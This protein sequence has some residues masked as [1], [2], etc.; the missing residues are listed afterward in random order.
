MG[1]N[2][3][4]R[5]RHRFLH[6]VPQVGCTHIS[7][8]TLKFTVEQIRPSS[9]ARISAASSCL[10]LICRIRNIIHLHQIFFVLMFF[11]K[12]K[13]AK[14]YNLTDRHTLELSISLHEI[15]QVLIQ[16]KLYNLFCHDVIDYT[17][18]NCKYQ[19]KI[20]EI[21]PKSCFLHDFFVY[22]QEKYTISRRISL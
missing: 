1:Y 14:P 16:T 7:V 4:G 15:V 9:L 22:F 6:S 21:C 11:V 10:T 19:P 3:N 2:F 8:T 17:T 5:N 18:N 12:I 13:D 20:N